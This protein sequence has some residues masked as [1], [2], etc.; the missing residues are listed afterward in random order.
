MSPKYS[1]NKEDG[2]KIVSGALVAISGALLTYTSQVITEIDFGQY[3]PIVVAIFSVLS[4]TL[5]KYLQG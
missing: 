4:N 5:R 3:T 1:L 2:K